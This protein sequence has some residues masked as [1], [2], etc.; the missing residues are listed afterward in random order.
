MQELEKILCYRRPD[1]TGMVSVYKIG[2]VNHLVAY[3]TVMPFVQKEI[4]C[5]GWEHA[6]MVFNKCK[7]ELARNGMVQ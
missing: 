1:G 6:Q 3:V 7:E 5:L 4:L 2:Q